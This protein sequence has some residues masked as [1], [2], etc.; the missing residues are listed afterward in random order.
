MVR[1]DAGATLLST[2]GGRTFAA[3]PAGTAFRRPACVTVGTQRWEIDPGGTV[4][5]VAN[6]TGAHG[7]CPIRARPTSAPVPI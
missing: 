4:R 5:H 3:A 1:T 6:V 7:R 2:D